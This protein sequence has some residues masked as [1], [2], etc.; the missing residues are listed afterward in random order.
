MLSLILLA[1]ATPDATPSLPPPAPVVAPAED[2]GVT[3]R[4]LVRLKH[5]VRLSLS[6][7][8]SAHA[9]RLFLHLEPN[10]TD[11]K[12]IVYMPSLKLGKAPDANT[13][14][15]KSDGA[16]RLELTLV[17]PLDAAATAAVLVVGEA[18]SPFRQAA[19][20]VDLTTAHPPEPPAT[21]PPAVISPGDRIIATYQS[22]LAELGSIVLKNGVAGPDG[23]GW[24]RLYTDL[25]DVTLDQV[26]EAI[27]HPQQVWANESRLLFI[28]KTGSRRAIGVEVAQG[29]VVSAR[30]I[31]KETFPRTVGPHTLYPNRVYLKK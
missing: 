3:V 5:A 19:V 29:E 10:E 13:R 22:P 6:I 7:T 11:A 24:T 23:R 27:A 2:F 31:T 25:P 26:A 18:A 28:A 4:G 30:A 12:G 1:L 8:N 15:L 9:E 14:F 17:F 21:P 16:E 20:P